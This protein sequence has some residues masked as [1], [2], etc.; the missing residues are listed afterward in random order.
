MKLILKYIILTLVLLN[1]PEALLNLMSPTLGTISSYGFFIFLIIYYILEDKSRLNIWM[2]FIGLLYYIVGSFQTYWEFSNF[3]NIFIKFIVVIIC[4]NELMKN[5]TTKELALFL[6]IGSATI[7]IN[8]I[9]FPDDYGR[10]SGV[11]FNPN[12]A[13]FIAIISFSLSF[14]L[15]NKKIKNTSSILSSFGGLLTFSR[16]FIILWILINLISIRLSIRNLKLFLIG[17]FSIF[18]IFTFADV[19]Q[20]N[21]IRLKQFESFFDGK[22]NS[23]Q[24]LQEDSRTKTWSKYYDSISTNLF[25]G[26]G[27]GSFQGGAFGIHRVGVHN[28]FLLVLGEAGILPFIL[29]VSLLI[30]LLIWSWKLFNYAPHLTMMTIGLFAVLMA[31]HGFFYYYYFPLITMWIQNQINIFKKKISYKS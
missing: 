22:N 19:L 9:F 11:Y 24:E 28:S 5:V 3:L 10:Y 6:G 23:T 17:G 26:N 15:I 21:T 8:S 31:D 30:Y 14:S 18:L 29:L 1:I 27:Y 12:A 16:T 2:L 4:G 25:I 13:G 7:V 20:L